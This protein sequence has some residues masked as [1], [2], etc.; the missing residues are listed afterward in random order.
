MLVVRLWGYIFYT[1]IYILTAVKPALQYYFVLKN[2]YNVKKPVR[3][4]AFRLALECADAH[5]L[6]HFPRK[7]FTRQLPNLVHEATWKKTMNFYGLNVVPTQ[8][9]CKI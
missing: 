8:R 6:M 7:K 9:S 4:G 5:C 3:R 1:Y 2:V